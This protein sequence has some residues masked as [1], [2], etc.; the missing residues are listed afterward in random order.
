MFFRSSV[1]CSRG[2]VDAYDRV[3]VMELAL[4]TFSIRRLVCEVV[5]ER[6]FSGGVRCL[7]GDLSWV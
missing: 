3:G 2:F 4:N 6:N 5:L 7:G 1:M